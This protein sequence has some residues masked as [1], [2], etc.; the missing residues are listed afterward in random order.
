M[1]EDDDAEARLGESNRSEEVEEEEVERWDGIV[2][3]R[4]LTGA[5]VDARDDDED[6]I[7]SAGSKRCSY[8]TY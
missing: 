8:L 5:V 3:R 2:G 4:F 1:A 6:A 7:E